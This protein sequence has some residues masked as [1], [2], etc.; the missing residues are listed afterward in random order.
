MGAC[1]SNESGGPAGGGTTGATASSGSQ[2]SGSGTSAAAGSGGS[3]SGSGGEGGSSGRPVT[4]TGGAGTST[5]GGGGAGG[6]GSGGGGTGGSSGG[7]GGSA[8][9]GSGGSGGQGGGTIGKVAAGVRWVGR[10]DTTDPTKPKFGWGGVGFVARI[11]GT[12]LSV[13]VNND[14]TVFFQPVV[15]GTAGPRLRAAAGMT[16]LQVATGLTAGTHTIELYRETE[17]SQGVTQLVGI[18]GSTLMSPPT[19][20]GRLI[21]TIGDSIS[22]GY[23]NLGTEV[24]TNNCST[25]AAPCHYTA[26]T[27]ADYQSY[28][29]LV[30]R[31]LNADYSIVANSGWGLYKD[32]SGGTTNLMPRVWEQIYM[33]GTAPPTWDFGIKADAVIINLGTNDT[34]GGRLAGAGFK[35][36]LKTFVGSVRSKYPSAWI[37]PVTGPMMSAASTTEIKGYMQAAITEL[38]DAKMFYVDLGTQACMS[39]GCDYHPNVA[40]HQRLAGILTPVVKAKLGW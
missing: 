20:S 21:E 38:G 3:T 40:E 9:S 10:V 37:F 26:D 28:S 25:N 7:Q 12:S 39:T 17:A 29:A 11:S 35:D 5:S 22:A 14:N 15:D 34:S 2:T 8:G 33:T 30:A 13:Q 36:A 24:H 27:Q 18:T 19:Y 23:G 16:T 32:I 6:I 1:T 31:A 4:S